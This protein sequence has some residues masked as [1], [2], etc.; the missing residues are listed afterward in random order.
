MGKIELPHGKSIYVGAH[1][2][3]AGIHRRMRRLS[4][5][6]HVGYRDQQPIFHAAQRYEKGDG[7]AF[8]YPPLVSFRDRHVMRLRPIA[9]HYA[10]PGVA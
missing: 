10:H 9:M 8:R 1:Q 4:C 3:Q 5:L 6:E 7:Q 2:R